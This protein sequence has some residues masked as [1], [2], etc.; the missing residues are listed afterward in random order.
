M[1]KYADKRHRLH[2]ARIELAMTRSVFFRYW[3]ACQAGIFLPFRDLHRIHY[4]GEIVTVLV[5]VIAAGRKHY[6]ELLV[7]PLVIA[8]G[9]PLVAARIVFGFGHRFPPFDTLDAVDLDP[10]DLL[11]FA[12]LE[13]LERTL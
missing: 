1:L 2:G 13:Q 9:Y 5:E 8:K 4:C 11:V 6:I 7:L 10:P 12:L 3:P